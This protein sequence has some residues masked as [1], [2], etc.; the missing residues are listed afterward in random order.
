MPDRRRGVIALLLLDGFGTEG[1]AVIGASRCF[2]CRDNRGVE[3]DAQLSGHSAARPRLGSFRRPLEAVVLV[4]A[5]LAAAASLAIAGEGFLAIV[6]VSIAIPAYLW[7][8]EWA[9]VSGRG[10][11][12]RR[13]IRVWNDAMRA[14]E[15][16]RWEWERLTRKGTARLVEL[17]PPERLGVH[18]DALVALAGQAECFGKDGWS[19]FTEKTGPWLQRRVELRSEGRR[20]ARSPS[21]LAYIDTVERLFE[22][23]DQGYA[24]VAEEEWR[25]LVAAIDRLGRM[26]RPDSVAQ[27]H[28]AL[29]AMLHEY[30]E[31][32]RRFAEAVVAESPGVA[33]ATRRLQSAFA[34]LEAW[35]DRVSARRQRE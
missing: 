33:D 24:K 14:V 8:Y 12:E 3:S 25:M 23:G 5:L 28:E 30:V 7:A 16:R 29:V 22:A 1:L 21:E 18:H 4:A 13:V 34:Q 10:A 2:F 31:A 19:G 27:E 20:M 9:P 35:R 15:A 17:A 26:R 6:C 32:E 11:Y